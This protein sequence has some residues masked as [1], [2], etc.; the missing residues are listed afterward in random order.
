[1]QYV[2][3][4]RTKRSKKGINIQNQLFTIHTPSGE[5]QESKKVRMLWNRPVLA[6]F[7]QTT[8]ATAFKT[9][10]FLLAKNAVIFVIGQRSVKE[11]QF[12]LMPLVSVLLL[13]TVKRLYIM[14]DCPKFDGKFTIKAEQILHARKQSALYL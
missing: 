7:K 5:Y 1:M 8:K 10:A 4:R 11:I 12:F 9:V 2:C 6:T 3:I 14:A 13:S